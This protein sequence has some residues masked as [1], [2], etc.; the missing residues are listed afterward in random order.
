[1]PEM[2]GYQS[3]TGHPRAGAKLEQPCPWKSPV[4]VIAMTA[5]AIQGDREK[6]LAA[7]MDRLS[8]QAGSDIRTS[9][10]A[11]TLETGG[12]ES[13]RSGDHFRERFHQWG[14]NQILWTWW[15]AKIPLL[16]EKLN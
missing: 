15:E 9:S 12:S 7:G 3:N 5:S 11:G 16:P 14:Q 10:S 8:Q 4:Y 6:C 2:D 1:M 13:N